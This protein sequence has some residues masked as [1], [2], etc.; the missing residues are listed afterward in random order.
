VRPWRR[1][2]IPLLSEEDEVGH[3]GREDYE[4][5]MSCSSM[6]TP[7]AFSCWRRRVSW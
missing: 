6:R 5:K 3:R 4:A 1:H 7:R 2:T